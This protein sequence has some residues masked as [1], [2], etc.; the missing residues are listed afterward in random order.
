MDFLKLYTE[1][2]PNCL[3]KKFVKWMKETA[4][5]SLNKS[6][7]TTLRKKALEYV[8]EVISRYRVHKNKASDN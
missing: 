2:I 6:I 3:Y 8:N 1:K 4:E 7:Y 5:I